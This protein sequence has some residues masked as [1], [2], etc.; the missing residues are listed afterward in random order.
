MT[1]SYNYGSH[2]IILK[3][4][5]KKRTNNRFFSF[6]N[7]AFTDNWK[8]ERGKKKRSTNHRSN[9]IPRRQSIISSSHIMSCSSFKKEWNIPKNQV[10]VNQTLIAFYLTMNTN[11]K[12]ILDGQMTKEPYLRA[13]CQETPVVEGSC[14]AARTRQS[15]LLTTLNL[16]PHS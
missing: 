11:F 2:S 4:K 13:N 5:W 12:H 15:R 10:L 9:I 7:D 6:S 14:T 3:T 1:I 16:C 8:N